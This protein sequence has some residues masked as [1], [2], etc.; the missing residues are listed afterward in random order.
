MG[1]RRDPGMGERQSQAAPGR[2]YVEC[3]V[4]GRK[5]MLTLDKDGNIQ[6]TWP[7]DNKNRLTMMGKFDHV[8]EIQRHTEERYNPHVEEIR[9]EWDKYKKMEHFA[10]KAPSRQKKDQ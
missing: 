5:G 10:V 1:D 2:N 7:E 9:E 8:R 4:C 3:A 6:Y